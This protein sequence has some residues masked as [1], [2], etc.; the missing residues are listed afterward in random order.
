MCLFRGENSRCGQRPDAFVS[1]I[2]QL[3]LSLYLSKCSKCSKAT[4][5]IHRFLDRRTM[6]RIKDSSEWVEGAQAGLF[7]FHGVRFS[8]SFAEQN[9]NRMPEAVGTL[10]AWFER[11]VQL[12]NDGRYHTFCAT[13]ELAEG[14]EL[15]VV[16]ALSGIPRFLLA[17]PKSITLLRKSWRG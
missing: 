3:S 5:F 14:D 6:D 4:H 2:S 13:R 8:T 15:P 7:L 9:M 11:G 1:Y 10:L 12:R 17:S 16:G